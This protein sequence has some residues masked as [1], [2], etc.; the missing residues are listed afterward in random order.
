MASGLVRVAAYAR[1]RELDFKDAEVA[2]FDCVSMS[3]CICNVVQSL[4]D[5]LEDLVLHQACLVANFNDE[6]P[7]R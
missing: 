3:Q 4:L 6:F 7:F 1:F 5:H 2:K